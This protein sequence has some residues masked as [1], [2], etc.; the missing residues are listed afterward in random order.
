MR[1]AFFASLA[2]ALDSSFAQTPASG[3]GY[4]AH[5]HELAASSMESVAAGTGGEDGSTPVPEPSTLLLVGTGLVGV[6]LT[7]RWRRRAK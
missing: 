6:A 4:D 3:P 5:R 7:A 2:L 1:L